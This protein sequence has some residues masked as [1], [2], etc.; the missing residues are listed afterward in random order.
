MFDFFK[1]GV[2]EAP[3]G[4]VRFKKKF[5]TYAWDIK[6]IFTPHTPD[7]WVAFFNSQTPHVSR[8][9]LK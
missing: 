1:S 9:K 2:E 7:G 4:S 6:I 8:Q 5:Q 3:G